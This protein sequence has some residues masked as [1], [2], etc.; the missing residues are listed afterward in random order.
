VYDDP[1]GGRSRRRKKPQKIAF[2][3]LGMFGADRKRIPWVTY[4]FTV[5]QIAVFI[6][7][8][9]RNGMSSSPLT[10]KGSFP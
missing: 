8:I 5:A 9:A 10:S 4:I 6:A 3:Q 7:E 2:G 1:R